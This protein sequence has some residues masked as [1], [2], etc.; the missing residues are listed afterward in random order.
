MKLIALMLVACAH[1]APPARTLQLNT[2][3]ARVDVLAAL[4]ADYVS[5]VD[6][7]ATWCEACKKWE[8]ALDAG[9]AD[10]PRVVIRKVDVGEAG[11]AVA[12]QYGITNLPHMRIYDRKRQLRYDLVGPDCERAAEYAKQLVAE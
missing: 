7:W 6:F 11:S 10:Q 8:A 12:Q 2:A 5:V 4:P 9:I 3:G 1:T